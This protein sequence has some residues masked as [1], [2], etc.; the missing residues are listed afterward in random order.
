MPKASKSKTSYS[1]PSEVSSL[2]PNL[3]CD[4]AKEM[5]FLLAFVVIAALAVEQADA[6]FSTEFT[7]MIG[8]ANNKV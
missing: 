1:Y 8:L 2:F 6:L 4:L 5:I 3:L 7:E